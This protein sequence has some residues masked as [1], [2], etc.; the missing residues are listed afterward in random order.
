M[1]EANDDLLRDEVDALRYIMR[2]LPVEERAEALDAP[3]LELEPWA[4]AI[5]G[6]FDAGRIVDHEIAASIL[7]SRDDPSMRRVKQRVGDDLRRRFLEAADSTT[8]VRALDK[9]H[10]QIATRRADKLKS[11]ARQ[12]IDR[13]DIDAAQHALR[14]LHAP[15]GNSHDLA[16]LWDEH[17]QMIGADPCADH[18]G[19][20]LHASRGKI[21]DFLNPM[22][23]PRAALT[24]GR[25]IL[26]GGAAG[27]GKTALGSLL[28]VDAMEAGCPVLFWQMELGVGETIEHLF[29]HQLV[30]G[31][32]AGGS[33]AGRVAGSQIPERW[34]QLLEIPRLD[35]SDATSSAEGL[36]QRMQRFADRAAA[37]RDRERDDRRNNVNGLVVVDYLQL[38]TLSSG[39]PKAAQHEILTTACSRLAKTAEQAGAVLVL[40]SQITKSGQ[41][42]G[43]SGLTGYSGADVARVAHVAVNINRA[44]LARDDEKGAAGKL[45]VCSDNDEPHRH[46]SSGEAR[47]VSVVK[48]RGTHGNPTRTKLPLRVQDR[49]FVHC[50]HD[51]DGGGSPRSGSPMTN[52]AVSSGPVVGGFQR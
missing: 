37:D 50:I 17:R 2:N 15:V 52:G 23:G 40:L 20:R 36:I 1:T 49:A 29:A 19:V 11:R 48:T 44:R 35:A 33:F 28:A 13:G 6:E 3:F 38:L 34:R 41:A 9:L 47:I 7:L 32:P 14:L 21:A 26:I 42:S 4:T 31:K 30:N 51:E 22:L 18:E 46:P 39:Q 12:A 16:S 45:V 10:E 8:G 5:R 27:A 43:A 24:P 25:T